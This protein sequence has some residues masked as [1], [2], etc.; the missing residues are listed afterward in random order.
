MIL[1]FV[2]ATNHYSKNLTSRY[3]YELPKK[4]KTKRQITGSLSI[5]NTEMK[6]IALERTILSVEKKKM[7]IKSWKDF[8]QT[9]ASLQFLSPFSKA[10]N[11]M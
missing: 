4:I 10:A 1:S 9:L 7:I 5:N 3:H 11:N 6:R 8:M 2:F